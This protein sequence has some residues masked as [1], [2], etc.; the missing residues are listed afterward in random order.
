MNRLKTET[1]TSIHIDS[2]TGTVTIK[3]TKDGVAQAKS[4]IDKVTSTTNS[5]NKK[6]RER[7]THF[8]SLPIRSALFNQ[9]VED[10]NTYCQQ[11]THNID[12][13]TLISTQ[14]LHITLGVMGLL[15]RL[16][17]DNA[18]KVLREECPDIVR[19]VMGDNNSLTIQLDRLKVMQPNPSNFTNVHTIRG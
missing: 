10:L 3:G 8:L 13:E 1:K 12:P 5:N 14:N 16:D 2:D 4:E 9:K 15:N 7:P 11:S 18:V 6:P 17:I 19:K